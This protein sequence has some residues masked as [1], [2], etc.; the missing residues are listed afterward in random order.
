MKKVFVRTWDSYRFKVRLIMFCHKY[1]YSN[2]T[3]EKSCLHQAEQ[4]AG[5][6]NQRKRGS[7]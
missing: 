3:L 7:A 1:V 5:S 2:L 4:S 6:Q